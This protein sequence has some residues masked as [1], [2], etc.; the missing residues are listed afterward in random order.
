M[1]N[2]FDDF[3]TIGAAAFEALVTMLVVFLAVAGVTAALWLA[4]VLV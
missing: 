2:E 4:W 1:D 3:T